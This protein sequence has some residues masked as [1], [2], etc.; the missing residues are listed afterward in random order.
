M[1]SCR[2]SNVTADETSS[3]GVRTCWRA[4]NRQIDEIMR[5]SDPEA[6]KLFR[7]PGGISPQW[8]QS[9][10]QSSDEG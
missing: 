4:T 8:G 2:P 1:H 3:A 9:Q 7:P 6:T 10:A 5:R